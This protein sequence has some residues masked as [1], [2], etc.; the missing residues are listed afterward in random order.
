MAGPTLLGPPVTGQWVPPLLHLRTE[1]DPVS[2]TCFLK[3]LDDGQSPKTLF[4]Q[5]FKVVRSKTMLGETSSSCGG[6]YEDGS[7]L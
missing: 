6:E 2:E 7:L 5:L 1:T 4:F 3:T